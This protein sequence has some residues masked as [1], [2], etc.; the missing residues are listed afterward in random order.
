VRSWFGHGASGVRRHK[1]G[2]RCNPHRQ[3]TTAA[4]D[5]LG[6]PVAIEHFTR[7]LAGVIIENR[8]AAKVIEANDDP[9][10]LFYVD[11]PYM[12]DV[13]SQ[14]RKAGDLYH[15]Y[16]HE[17]EDDD[18]VALLA[19][20]RACQGMVVLSGYAHALYDDV[21]TDWRRVT[22]ATQADRREAREEVLW[23]NPAACAAAGQ[24]ALDLAI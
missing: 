4:D 6:W 14:K 8:P 24:G 19:Q 11:P 15:G 18:H 22:K 13:R 9:H 7:R 23:I 20:L 3:R 10:T 21:L 16:K 2:F 5:W 1:T 17:L 12:F